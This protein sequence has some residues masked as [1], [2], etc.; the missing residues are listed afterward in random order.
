MENYLKEQNKDYLIIQQAIAYLS[1][2]PVNEVELAKFSHALGLNERQLSSLFKRWCGLSP[3]S[4]MQAVALDHAKKL[5]TENANIL[6]VSNE[7]GLSSTSRLYDLFVSHH[8]MPP[9]IW[10]NKG[11]GLHMVWG[12]APSPFGKSMLFSTKYGL[13]GLAFFDEN[14][15]QAT[16]D[17]MTNR[18]PKAQFSRNDMQVSVIATRIFDK[19]KWDKNNPIKVIFIGTDFEIR[20]WQGLLEIPLG[21]ATTYGALAEEINI[22]KA[23]RAVGRAIGRNPISFVVPCHRVIGKNGKLT[24]YHWGINRKRAML[25]WEAGVNNI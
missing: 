25:G 21:V 17:D 22:P 13:A 24:G 14:N 10:A 16:Y 2:Q 4:F 1:N 23:T 15:Q 20:V 19:E 9:G 5:L 7:I 8:A 18:W 11:E 12:I 3:K 6:Q